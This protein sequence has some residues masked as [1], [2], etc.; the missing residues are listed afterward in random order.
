MLA[1]TLQ[2][3]GRR[4][5]ALAEAQLAADLDGGK[6]PEVAHVLQGLAQSKY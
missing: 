1:Q 6:N 3:K 2:T 4:D 5:Q